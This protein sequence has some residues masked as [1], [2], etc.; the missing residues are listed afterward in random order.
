MDT[1]W[2]LSSG[3]F[4]QEAHQNKTGINAGKRTL[5]ICGHNSKNETEHTKPQ[6]LKYVAKDF[7]R[8]VEESPQSAVEMTRRNKGVGGRSK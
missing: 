3:E 2:I 6:Y 7:R 1:I 5:A 4:V 8:I